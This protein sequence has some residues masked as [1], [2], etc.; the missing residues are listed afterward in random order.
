MSINKS[1]EPSSSKEVRKTSSMNKTVTQ[2]AESSL[3]D[4]ISPDPTKDPAPKSKDYNKKGKT[5]AK[6]QS[7]E[8]LLLKVFAVSK[9]K[10]GRVKPAKV[11]KNDLKLLVAFN[12][13]GYI[14]GKNYTTLCEQVVFTDPELNCLAS[15]VAHVMTYKNA[16]TRSDLLNICLRIIS[17]SWVNKHRRSL[18]LYRDIYD[19]L[20]EGDKTINGFERQI[21]ILY[22]KRIAALSK[23]TLAEKNILDSES[24][25]SDNNAS[26]RVL[27]K[28]NLVKQKINLL[29]VGILWLI[30][31]R[32]IDLDTS[33][34]YLLNYSQTSSEKKSTLKDV[35]IYL[36]NQCLTPEP[37]L[38]KTHSLLVAKLSSLSE[39]NRRTQQILLQRESQLSKLQ[40]EMALRDREKEELRKQTEDSQAS[41][42]ELEGQLENQ[43][44]DE[45]ASRSHLRDS[46]EKVR[47]RALNLLSEEI[48]EPLRLSLK[49]LQRDNPKTEQAAHQIELAIESIERDLPWFKESE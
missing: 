35:A 39:N 4:E 7:V 28:S 29:V 34:D 48:L 25:G 11:S 42:E 16:K 44:L 40:A 1:S 17:G 21:N 26:S 2:E 6:Y 43:K 3:P 24:D 49:A 19:E 46:E 8:E 12:D 36:A 20:P 30:E 22:D 10:T 45:K 15:I 23:G 33:I 27:T 32:L 47:S 38:L 18:N 31:Q 9:D 13:V 41:I 5:T 37:H 14:Q